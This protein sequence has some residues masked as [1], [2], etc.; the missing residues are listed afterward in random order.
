MVNSEKSY[1]LQL[2]LK[3]PQ[4]LQS[5]GN[6]PMVTGL[7]CP[8]IGPEFPTLWAADSSGQLT[9]WYVPASGLE[10]I[11]AY[12]LVAHQGAINDITHTWRHVITVGDDGFIRLFDVLSFATIKQID[13]M[14]W[15][16]YRSLL[17]NPHIKRKIKVI[18]AQENYDSG[19]HIVVGT[20]Y[21]DIILLSLG[22][23]V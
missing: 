2:T 22:T 13:V 21:G 20:T 10:Y 3:L 1:C 5:S 14:Y 17:S 19:G 7:L 4:R 15:C 11:P 8:K 9:I 12:T 16:A 6:L 18:H 23:T